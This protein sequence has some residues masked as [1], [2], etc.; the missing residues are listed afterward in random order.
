MPNAR[1]PSWD[2]LD[3]IN[4]LSAHLMPTVK[5]WSQ[6]LSS[7]AASDETVVEDLSEALAFSQD[8]YQR[9]RYLADECGWAPDAALVMLLDRSRVTHTAMLREAWRD[10]SLAEGIRFN[11][12]EGDRVSFLDADTGQR[13]SGTVVAAFRAEGYGLVSVPGS[14]GMQHVEVCAEQLTHEQPQGTGRT[15]LAVAVRPFVGFCLDQVV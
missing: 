3:V 12:E 14:S 4:R 8:G 10:W 15:H 2:D 1:R 5:S 6:T 9:A 7:P 13:N 11:A